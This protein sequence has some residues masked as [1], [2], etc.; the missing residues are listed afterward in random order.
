MMESKCMAAGLLIFDNFLVTFTTALG[1]CESG[2]FFK[3]S[4]FGTID[5]GGFGKVE[6]F[7]S[8]VAVAELQFGT[9]LKPENFSIGAGFRNFGQ[10]RESLIRL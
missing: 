4:D 9:T 2:W 7:E 10:R 1:T 8:Q 3:K 5:C 6:L